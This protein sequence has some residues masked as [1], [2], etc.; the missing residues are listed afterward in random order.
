MRSAGEPNVAC[1]LPKEIAR[2]TETGVMASKSTCIRF[3]RLRA[4]HSGMDRFVA[5]GLPPATRLSRL[6]NP[7]PNGDIE[8]LS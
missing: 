4:A 2:L 6:E 5:A 8:Y 1:G 3:I 7:M